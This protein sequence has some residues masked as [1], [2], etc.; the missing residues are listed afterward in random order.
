MPTA[1]RSPPAPIRWSK[2][3]AAL[4]AGGAGWAVGTSNASNALSSAYTVSVIGQNLDLTVV[5]TIT[6]GGQDPVNGSAWDTTTTN[7]FSGNSGTTFSTNANVSFNDTQ[8]AGGPPVTN[9]NITIINGGVSP[10]SVS[11]G[12][13]STPG[14]GVA[15]TINSSDTIGITGPTGITLNGT[16]TVTLTGMNSYIGTTFLNAGT[17]VISNNNSLG[18]TSGTIAPITFN[19]GTLR[20]ATGS[21]NTDISDRTVTINPAGATIDLNGNNVTYASSIG[22][23]GNLTLI[24]SG[25]PATLTLASNNAFG[26]STIIS[27]VLSVSTDLNLGTLPAITQPANITING[28]TLQVAGTSAYDTST[29][30]PLRGITLGASGGTINIPVTGSG[31][32]STTDVAVMYSGIIAGTAGGNLT[33]TG[34]SGTNS[35]A[36]P[37]LL[38]LG[39]EST[40]NGSTTISNATVS[41]LNE[42][43]GTQISNDLPVT[44][45]LNLIDNAWFVMNNNSS[46][47]QVAGLIGDASSFIGSTN[48]GAASILTV[49]PANG[50]SYTYPGVIGPLTVLGKVGAAATTALTINGT[51]TGTEILTGANTYG[52]ATTISA[53]TLQI[54]NGGTTGTLGTG[55]VVDNSNLTFDRSDIGLIVGNVISGTGAVQ[56]IG[57]GTTSL[58]ATNTYAGTTTISSGTL[59]IGNGGSTGSL[60]TGNV[61]NN[62]TLAFNRT[63]TALSVGNLISGGGT[64]QQVGTG[65]STLAGTNSYSGGTTVSAGTLVAATSSALGTGSVTLGGATLRVV[66]PSNTSLTGFGGNGSSFGASGTANGWTVNT[67]AVTTGAFPATNVLQL[68]D[69]NGSEAR[70]AFY[71]TLVPYQSGSAGFSASFTYTPSGTKAADGVAFILQNDPR[72]TAAL[73]ATGG[74]F[75]YTGITPSFGATLNIYTTAAGGIGIPTTLSTN[76]AIVTNTSVSP[77]SLG[78]GD[79]INVSLVY[80]P[81]ARRSPKRWS[82]QRITTRSPMFTPASICRPSWAGAAAPTSALA[83]APAARLPRNKSAI[84][85]IR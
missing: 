55:S 54:G 19:G 3:P 69:N 25:A 46:N 71:D 6:W 48:G 58:T 20:Y 36:S 35:G 9:N 21:T 14:T 61:V 80:S 84:S 33:I 68:T 26:S 49:E 78:S 37:Y 47:Q 31:A 43:G 70:S 10:A 30:S 18:S 42:T 74:S 65:T 2:T 38:E 51:G 1:V 75:G 64:V 56:Q 63:D 28:G 40:Y 62:G 39:G 23:A 41:F 67:T 85:P 34:G 44:T 15:Y 73:G 5:S 12:N 7:W 77:V 16:G 76:G 60:G 52:G 59:R 50:Q 8:Y 4:P 79:P 82:I 66:G 13:T 29:I 24:D 53:G 72:G 45:V 32:F 83:A 17:L 22:G 57:S 27:G 81:S 11:F